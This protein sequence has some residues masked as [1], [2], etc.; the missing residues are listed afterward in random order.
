MGEG[1][2]RLDFPGLGERAVVPWWSILGLWRGCGVAQ[3]G[4]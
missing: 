1:L 4:G 2:K 3:E